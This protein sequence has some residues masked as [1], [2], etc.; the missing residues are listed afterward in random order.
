[1]NEEAG[2]GG[3]LVVALDLLLL[4]IAGKAGILIFL[5]NRNIQSKT[6]SYRCTFYVDSDNNSGIFI[7][8]F[9]RFHP[10]TKTGA[11]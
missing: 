8:Q 1:M 2:A 10:L 6:I 11:P 7:A 9:G 5:N 4:F 3:G